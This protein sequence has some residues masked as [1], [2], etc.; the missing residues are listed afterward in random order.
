MLFIVSCGNEYVTDDYFDLEELGGYV[1]FDASGN[2]AYLD[3]YEV[4][5]DGAV[6]A[7]DVENPTGTSSDIKVDYSFG[8]TAE[9]GIDYEDPNGSASGGSI[10]ISSD[11][12][13]FNET[14][15]APITLTLLNDEIFDGAKTILVTLTGASNADGTILV[16]RGGKDFLKTAIVNIADDECDSQYAGSYAV[17]TTTDSIFIDG[18][19]TDSIVMFAGSATLANVDGEFFMYD[20]DDASGGFYASDFVGGGTL[21]LT[22]TEDCG[23]ITASSITDSNGQSVTLLSGSIGDGGVVTLSFKGDSTGNQFTSVFTPN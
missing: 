11:V 17:A 12:G 3:P 18:V 15:Q 2:D 19:L 8:G 13:N 1:A 20:V 16:G 10:T 21:P 9:Y 5:E 14:Y 23:A 6:V 4:T 7:M 22:F